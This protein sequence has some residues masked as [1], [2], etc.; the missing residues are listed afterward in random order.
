MKREAHRGPSA[1][2]AA[3]TA[4]QKGVW[5]RIFDFWYLLIVGTWVF[6]SVLPSIIDPW[7][8]RA[9]IMVVFI[10]AGTLLWRGR[11]RQRRERLTKIAKTQRS[12]EGWI[13][14]PNALPDSLRRRWAYGKA[15]LEEGAL[16]FQPL[17]GEDGPPIGRP[18][19][20]NGLAYLGPRHVPTKER[21][22]PRNWRVVALGTDKGEI[23]LRVP[24]EGESVL[25]SLR[26]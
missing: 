12:F 7:P 2:E 22:V 24:P 18:A 6:F 26:A 11:N 19:S 16:H 5:E 10:G 25:D 17:S 4:T 13:R 8:V 20:Y 1:Q 14:H 9:A 15:Q 21:G 23:E 3:E